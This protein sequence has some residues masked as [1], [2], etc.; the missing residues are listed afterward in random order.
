MLA[1]VARESESIL[2]VTKLELAKNRAKINWLINNLAELRQGVINDTE[3][4]MV[5]L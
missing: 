5:E 1:Q 3:N 4:V 2:N